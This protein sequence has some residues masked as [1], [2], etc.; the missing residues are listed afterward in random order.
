MKFRPPLDLNYDQRIDS[1]DLI[2]LANGTGSGL[3]SGETL[4]LTIEKTTWKSTSSPRYYSALRT[5]DRPGRER[6]R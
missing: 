5:G 6:N 4:D 1:M 2:A 3:R